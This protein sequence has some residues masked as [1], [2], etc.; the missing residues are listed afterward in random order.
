MTVSLFACRDPSLAL[1]SAGGCG[2]P[3]KARHLRRPLRHPGVHFVIPADAGISARHPALLGSCVRCDVG[4]IPAFAGMTGVPSVPRALCG[5]PGQARHPRRPLRHPGGCRDLRAAPLCFGVAF[6][7]TWVR[8][9]RRRDD[10]FAF[11][12]SR[13]L[14]CTQFRGRMRSSRPGSSSQASTPSSRRMPGS[15]RGTALLRSCVRCDVGE[16]PAFA[17]MTVSPF[18]C[19]DPSR[20]LSSAGACGRPGEAGHPCVHFVIPADAGISA[21]HRSASTLRSL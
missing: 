10:G 2:R 13:P 15:P 8:S 4:E 14:A 17:G 16:I 19:R 7:L 9:G 5:H 20:A 3:G 11:R 18:A 6:A 1:S 12:L 21:R